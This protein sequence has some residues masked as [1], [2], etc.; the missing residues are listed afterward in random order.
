MKA[1][2][3]ADTNSKKYNHLNYESIIFFPICV[4]AEVS[5]ILKLKYTCKRISETFERK[6]NLI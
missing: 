4:I 5:L 3:E 1:F 2:D 6:F